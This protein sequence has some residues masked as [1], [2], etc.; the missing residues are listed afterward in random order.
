MLLVSFAPTAHGHPSLTPGTF[1][2]R[3]ELLALAQAA[4]AELAPPGQR[5]G[6]SDTRCVTLCETK[7]NPGSQR[8]SRH[9]LVSPRWVTDCI[10]AMAPL[11]LD[12]YLL[13]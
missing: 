12:A 9:A 1:S 10:G 7:P 4:G 2:T 3:E 5:Y 8:A 6:G 11:P 13:A